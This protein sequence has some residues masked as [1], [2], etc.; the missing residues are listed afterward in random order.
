MIAIGTRAHGETRRRPIPVLND[1]FFKAEWLETPDNPTLSPTAF[2][3]EQPPNTTLVPHFHKNNQFQ[4]FVDGSGTIGRHPIGPVTVHYAGAFTGYG[5]LVS[6][7]NGIKYFT[8]VRSVKAACTP[9]SIIAL[10]SSLA[11]AD[12]RA[13]RHLRLWALSCFRG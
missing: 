5:P 8:C 3:V 2:L 10:T 11:P 9:W 13:R 6:G 1:T 12:M 7:S 4:L